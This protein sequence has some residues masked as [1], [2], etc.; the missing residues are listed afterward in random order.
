MNENT[1]RRIKLSELRA[2]KSELV[3]K[4][5]S[6]LKNISS[7][8]ALASVVPLEGLNL[9]EVKRLAD[10]AW[11]SYQEFIAVSEGI[12]ILRGEIGE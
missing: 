9:K 6:D 7:L 3:V 4:I 8:L 12:N 2:I 5:K 11:E 10:D 1:V